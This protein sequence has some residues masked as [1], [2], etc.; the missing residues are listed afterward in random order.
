VRKPLAIVLL[1]LLAVAGVACGS[2]DPTVQGPTTDGP[3]ATGPT[4]EPS[5]PTT[6]PG[7][8]CDDQT[9]DDTAEVAMEDSFFDPECLSV[10]RSSSL[11]LQ[12][13]GQAAHTFTISG[14]PV[15]FTI[16]PG[17]DQTIDGP[18]P[19]EPGEYTFYC[20]FHGSAAGSGMAGSITIV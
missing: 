12:N 3:T 13:N 6:D 1:L 7:D 10:D 5:T 17:Q 18:A 9:G 19:L 14:T 15:D 16:Q 11:H 20:K 8:D 2:D 4:D